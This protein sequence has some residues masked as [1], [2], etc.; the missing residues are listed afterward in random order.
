VEDNFLRENP[1]EG[2]LPE[3]VETTIE[4]QEVDKNN[5][6][7]FECLKE[8]TKKIMNFVNN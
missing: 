1:I 4:R 8:S 3:F 5:E 6:E 2:F 7:S